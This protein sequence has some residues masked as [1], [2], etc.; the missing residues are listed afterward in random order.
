MDRNNKY[1]NLIETLVK[2][3]K[4]YRG[5]ETLLEDIIDDVYK[6]SSVV[7]NSINNED[8]IN[9]YL[10]KIISTSI[11][12]VSRK[13]NF[14]IHKNYR[15]ID[16]SVEVKPQANVESIPTEINQEFNEVAAPTV[17]QEPSR[18]ESKANPELVDRMI[19][20]IQEDVIADKQ[21]EPLS[22]EDLSDEL[23][24]LENLDDNIYVENN[25]I[26]LGDDEQAEDENF[27]NENSDI[28]LQASDLISI[29][30]DNELET[31]IQE[32]ANNEILDEAV[33]S[34]SESEFEAEV[35]DTDAEAL[36]TEETDDT[37]N[38]PENFEEEDSVE[39]E[40]SED[41]E[42]SLDTDLEEDE[43]AKYE[44]NIIGY[45]SEDGLEEKVETNDIEVDEAISEDIPVIENSESE[46]SEINNDVSSVS[47]EE[48]LY[49]EDNNIIEPVEQPPLEEDLTEVSELEV[50]N[51]EDDNI[52]L[53]SK[54]TYLNIEDDSQNESGL[55]PISEELSL[56]E[57][58]DNNEPQDLINN[59]SEYEYNESE[60]F[61][62]IP[63]SEDIEL[64]ENTDN[65]L[66][67]TIFTEETSDTSGMLELKEDEQELVSSDV[68][69]DDFIYGKEEPASLFEGQEDLSNSY[70]YDNLDSEEQNKEVEET[71]AIVFK[72]IDYTSFNKARESVDEAQNSEMIM[73]KL[74]ALN[75][76][77][78]EL[79]IKE[80]YNLKYEQNLTIAEIASRLEISKKD[81]IN[82]IDNIIEI[83]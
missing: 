12:T 68:N 18:T 19:N 8:V 52:E 67:D 47:D 53:A 56:V 46:L 16:N 61:A 14:D 39:L 80:I 72:D 23:T 71:A 82:A 37:D 48:A 28:E 64:V 7:L 34:D 77:K 49:Q 36:I 78:P 31:E 21:A 75:I 2:Q 69:H 10:Q 83:V 4:K 1:Y 32:D 55:E 57:D 11:I 74:E 63:L 45:E 79:K 3:N 33:F 60:G 54:D 58:F 13:M 42:N 41:E 59:S 22:T 17:V 66:N 26:E 20:S 51:T 43:E 65:S 24:E 6:H 9:A 62:E 76:E 73:S 70:F 38:I 25:E 30:E 15:V 44:D 35:A 27:G 81:V 50:L 5:M 40:L 29:E